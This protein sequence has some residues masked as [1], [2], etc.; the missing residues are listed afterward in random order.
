MNECRCQ[1]P[2]K[3]LSGMLVQLGLRIVPAGQPK[4]DLAD[5]EI[6]ALHV[7]VKKGLYKVVPN[8]SIDIFATFKQETESNAYF[9]IA[10]RVSS[11]Y[12]H[13]TK[14]TMRPFLRYLDSSKK[15]NIKIKKLQFSLELTLGVR[16][17]MDTATRIYRCKDYGEVN[18]TQ[19]LLYQNH[20][21]GP[22][23]K[24]RYYQVL[25][26]L[27]YCLQVELVSGEFEENDGVVTINNTSPPLS[28]NDYY[29]VSRETPA[30][31]RICAD[32]Y[33]QKINSAQ[34]CAQEFSEAILLISLCRS[35]QVFL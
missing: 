19:T 31:I 1:Q 7:A 9:I 15:L 11:K 3:I 28:V 18:N 16:F 6:R 14:P 10:V 27:M 5:I 33:F 8:V 32:T 13:D 23:L 17:W 4:R 30:P 35:F 24:P 2:M 29:R 26:P 22:Q 20:T 34:R 12:G 25:S 21:L